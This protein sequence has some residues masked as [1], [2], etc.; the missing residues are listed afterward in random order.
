MS[1]DIHDNDTL[2]STKRQAQA[3]YFSLNNV[4]TIFAIIIGV[5]FVGIIGYSYLSLE[6]K[7]RTLEHKTIVAVQQSANKSLS[8]QQELEAGPQIYEVNE[9]VKH[10]TDI[11]QIEANLEEVFKEREDL[12]SC[13]RWMTLLI[14]T[15]NLQES[16]R[17]GEP[18]NVELASLSAVGKDDP[19]IMES[20]LSLYEVSKEEIPDI[21]TLYMEM[22]KLSYHVT[23]QPITPVILGQNASGVIGNISRKLNDFVKVEKVASGQKDVVEED[24]I[25]QL[26]IAFEKRDWRLVLDV[27]HK[28]PRYQ[29]ELFSEWEKDIVKRVEIQSQ[30]TNLYK[31]IITTYT[32]KAKDKELS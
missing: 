8:Y 14:T 32:K 27:L 21:P 19:L 6:R 11:K 3:E 4:L 18:I 23:V 7:V 12:S 17:R 1:H 29:Q 28:M 13:E 10:P 15:L 30:L 26:H 9:A 24:M 2:P 5:C 16:F 31:H 22:R 20:I 25:N